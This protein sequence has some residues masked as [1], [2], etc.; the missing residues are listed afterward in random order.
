M[1][2]PERETRPD[3]IEIQSL[4]S[5]PTKTMFFRSKPNSGKEQGIEF[6]PF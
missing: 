2:E 4:R 3:K 5:S 6:N 1:I